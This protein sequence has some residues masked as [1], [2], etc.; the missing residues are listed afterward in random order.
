MT[1]PELDTTDDKPLPRKTA[2]AQ[3]QADEAGG[4]GRSAKVVAHKTGEEFIVPS[5]VLLDDDQ[6]IAYEALHH[7]L[8]QCDR[9]PDFESP[10]QQFV[11]KKPDGSVIETKTGGYTQRGGFVQPYQKDGKLVTP[12]YSIQLAV[13]FWGETDYKRFKEGGGRSAEIPEKLR[14]L[15]AEMQERTAADSKSVG[16]S[17][18]LAPGT[19]GDRGGSPA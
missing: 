6:L 16:R 9:E 3:E 5:V 15:N 1:Q 13:I 2:E 14:Q 4:F 10:E 17:D 8:N 7:G 11:N 19:D 12:P 18:D